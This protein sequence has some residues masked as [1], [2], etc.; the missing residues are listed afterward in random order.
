MNFGYPFLARSHMDLIYPYIR[1]TYRASKDWWCRAAIP[2]EHICGHA[3]DEGWRF[4]MVEGNKQKT[5]EFEGP[6]F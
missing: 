6:P 3:L 2:S 4:L 1:G 5:A